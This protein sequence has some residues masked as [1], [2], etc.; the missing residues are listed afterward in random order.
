[1]LSYENSHV[2]KFTGSPK[3]ESSDIFVFD[4]FSSV[5]IHNFDI[6]NINSHDG[7]FCHGN[8]FELFCSEFVYEKLLQKA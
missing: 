3:L 1:V 6:S 5:L 4:S 7:I 2:F 8:T